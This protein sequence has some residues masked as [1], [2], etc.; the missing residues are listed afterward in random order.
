VYRVTVK[1]DISFPSF[2]EDMEEGYSMG[3]EDEGEEGGM[4]EE[5]E[6][7]LPT[8]DSKS[9]RVMARPRQAGS[10]FMWLLGVKQSGFSP[11]GSQVVSKKKKDPK[12]KEP[13]PEEDEFPEQEEYDPDLT[14]E[15]DWDDE[16][17]GSHY[18]PISTK[19]T[20]NKV[21]IPLQIFSVVVADF[22]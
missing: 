9:G 4:P 18:A 7:E 21:R 20:I 13:E 14:G 22:S 3:D 12:Y 17:A 10:P 1:F 8:V 19:I 16:E 2:D 15:E 5:D 6:E 11:S